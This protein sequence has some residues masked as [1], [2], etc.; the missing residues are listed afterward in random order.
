MIQ[1][2]PVKRVLRF[3]SFE[4]KKLIPDKK[5]G[6]YRRAKTTEQWQISIDTRYRGN[7]LN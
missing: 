2:F 6:K 3:Y 5:K 1:C 4:Y 7:K